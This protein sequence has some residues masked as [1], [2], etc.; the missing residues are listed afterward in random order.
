ML[1][2]GVAGTAVEDQDNEEAAGN[3]KV[4]G[5]LEDPTAEDRMACIHHHAV[6]CS[7]LEVPS[8]CDSAQTSAKPIQ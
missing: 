2:E 1:E 8:K 6:D 7:Y 4:G 3:H 5:Q